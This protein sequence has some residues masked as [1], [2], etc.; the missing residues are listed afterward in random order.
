[1]SRERKEKHTGTQNKR[2]T[3]GFVSN[4]LSDE[5]ACTL[6]QGA[7]DVARERDV[8][9]VYFPACDL[10]TPVGFDAQANVLY[11]IASA[12]ALD[13]LVIWTASLVNY[14]GLEGAKRVLERY[15][16]MPIVLI[17]AG[18]PEDIPRLE[19]DSY[20]PMRQAIVHL[21]KEHGYRRVAFIRGPDTT[22]AGARQR[23]QA[24]QDVLAE[25]GLPFDPDLVSPPSEGLWGPEVG[26]AAIALLLDQ[27]HVG[28]EAVVAAN[29]KIAIGAM[30]ALQARGIH[31]PNQVAVA[32]Y[33]DEPGS[34]STLP[35]LTTVPLQG[36]E[37]GRQA[38]E[39]LLTLLEGGQVPDQV[40]L[41][42][43]LVV[44]QSC[45]CT[46][47][48]VA[49]AAAKPVTVK[50]QQRKELGIAQRETMLAEMRQAA[51]MGDKGLERGWAEQL[52]ETFFA[53]LKADKP[54][55]FLSALDG[56]LRRVIAVGGQVAVWANVISALRRC[57]LPHLGDSHMLRRADDL[58]LQAQVLI[59]ET[60][61]LAHRRQALHDKQRA[62]VL[63][64][65]SAAL[66]TT[67]NVE[68]LMD[69]LAQEL[70]RLG[71]LGCY[72]SLYEDPKR[73]S[74]TSR[75]ILAYDENG[76]VELEP[77][78]QR[79]LS[80]Q[81]LP[82]RMWLQRQH[83][84]V[85]EPLYF[86]QAQL[87]FALFKV[88][89]REGIVYE[90]LRAQISS[91]LQGALLVRQ[92]QRRSAQLQ[93][94]SEVSRAASSI[95]DPAELTQQV[96][97]LIR[98]R[99]DLYY[100]GLFLVDESGEWAVLR[101]GTGAAGQKM[102]EQ[103]HRLE[104]GGASMI[105]WCIAN[106]QA[107]I[108]LDVGADA[109][110]VKNPLLPGTCSELAL[111]LLSR[112]DAIGA[113]TIQSTQEAAFSQEDIAVLQ[114]MADQ[115]ANAIA[116]ARLFE[117]AQARTEELAALDEMA[118]ALTTTLDIGT[119]LENVYRHTSHLMDAAN[120]YVA[121]Y[122]ARK[123][124]VSFPFYRVEGEPIG[125][126]GSRQAGKGLTE[127]VIRTG[128]PL[129]VEENIAAQLK[130][131]GIEM[132]GREALSWLGAPMVTSD[133]VIG[134]IA[135]Q[136]YTTPRVYNEHHRDLLSA[137]A[138]QT[139]IAIQNARLFEQAQIRAAEL[140]ALNE[141]GQALAARLSIDEVLDEV[142]RGASRLMDAT[143]FYVA[144]YDPDR[145]EITFPLDVTRV[146]K[147][148]FR[149]LSTDEGLTGYI[150]RNRISVLIQENLPERL[151]QIGVEMIG[152]P[153]L[154]WLG[155]P[156]MI[157]D[158][159]LG[160]LGVQSY[161]TP[162]AYD[163]HHRDLLTALASQTAIA[164]Q[165]ARLFERTQAALQES[166][167]T[168]RRYLQQAW[169]DYQRTARQTGY[170]TGRPEGSLLG[171]AVLP[172]V[173]QAMERR[174][175]V[176][177]TGD[178]DGDG[179][180]SALIMPVAIRDTIIGALGIHAADRARQ[181]TEDEIALAEAIAERMALAAENL[182][183]LDETQRRA[184]RERLIGEVAGRVRESFDMEAV[185]STAAREISRALGLA[186]LDVRLGTAEELDGAPEK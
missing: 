123:N 45:G 168:H 135:V 53:D 153:A 108:A 91:A 72:L 175:A 130:E 102:L 80:R 67:F 132:I 147:D 21:V 16:A 117:Q 89:P 59:G 64:E 112:G 28:F 8:N 17:E 121:L 125:Q 144:L 101:A 76:R 83:S 182:R 172:E 119:M 44:R 157:G 82:E 159:V 52:L 128:R 7:V 50:A 86:R 57:A 137:I 162:H 107:R 165:N 164:I 127:H 134:V 185:L 156:M 104:I 148:R 25:Y 131:L 29:D 93:T 88:G 122:D 155:V 152:Q 129:L 100:V 95:L 31:V 179:G 92:T 90:T 61:Q 46:N 120:L 105:G 60:A 140:A 49:Q 55:A 139:A 48:A 184:E 116:N 15:R 163:E 39:A 68:A 4:R 94:A 97:N 78:G 133:K 75:L 54:G 12:D 20:H 2:P 37:T 73:P 141:L 115:L 96:V 171:D 69:T 30:Q 79:F 118:R 146:E 70:P 6:W 66:I 160:V 110:R 56:V 47:P 9:M 176:T 32:G 87:G 63:D 1:M 85:V 99:F 167:A 3:I 23:Y 51:G 5:N 124:E 161:T 142:H 33:D 38:V 150:I 71:I 114:T 77:K 42:P 174:G 103:G 10:D 158:Q 154:S 143:N 18:G 178:G 74:E 169:A 13:G 113:L 58:W 26:E 43:K 106:K 145:D 166:E 177:L 138:N 84:L 151:A 19:V 98:Q 35:P 40:N 11:D 111:P 170:E 126:V 173:R 34:N 181:W 65:I 36:Y 24:Y 14:A 183:L 27:R 180:Y 22:H 109:V 186:A 41:P 81:L 62:Q 136:S 149:T